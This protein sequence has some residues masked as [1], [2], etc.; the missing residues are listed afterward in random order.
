MK[1]RPGLDR[2]TIKELTSL[3]TWL[4]SKQ[5][6]HVKL[7]YRCRKAGKNHRAKCDTWWRLARKLFTAKRTLENM[8]LAVNPNQPMLPG[9]EE[10]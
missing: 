10:L 6:A 3:K 4:E 1:T 9:M 2:I 5:A 7:C 8:K